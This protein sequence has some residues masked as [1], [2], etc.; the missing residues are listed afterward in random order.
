MSLQ[1][2]TEQRQH[3]LWQSLSLPHIRGMM[4]SFGI[5]AFMSPISVF[6]ANNLTKVLARARETSHPKGHPPN[7]Q[8]QST[9]AI[10]VRMIA[11]PKNH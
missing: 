1:L 6:V 4:Q 11:T 8:C 7:T 10:L 9:N 2:T 5:I 3:A